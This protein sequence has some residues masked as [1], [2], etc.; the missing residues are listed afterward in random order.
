MVLGERL[1]R[2]GANIHTGVEV[3]GIERHGETFDLRL[4]NGELI[5]AECIIVAT[6]AFRAADLLSGL[7]ASLAADLAAIPHVST[8]IVTLAYRRDD[9]DH[10]LS[11]HGYVVPRIEGSPILA[12][13]WSSRKWEHRAPAGWELIRVFLGRSGQLQDEVINA[14]NDVFVALARQEAESRLGIRTAPALTRVHRWPQAM[15]QYHL[16]HPERVARIGNALCAQPG[17]FLA[18]N[19]YSGVGLP[20]CIASGER[21]AEA[22]GVYLD[23]V[24]NAVDDK[25]G[26]HL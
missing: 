19:A 25:V 6:P 13:T 1:Q 18:G 9:I 11:G 15:P 22:S 7:D 14:D 3:Q 23:T 5:S 8:A 21:A 24:I 12:C 20:D 17:L 2:Q 16:G 4:P 10:P 26:L